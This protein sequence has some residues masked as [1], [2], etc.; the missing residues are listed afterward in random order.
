MAGEIGIEGR[1]CHQCALIGADRRGDVPQ[2]HGLRIVRERRLEQ[3]GITRD[4]SQA[5]DYSLLVG[6]TGCDRRGECLKYL[7][8]EVRT[9][10][11]PMNNKTR[12]GIK[13]GRDVA[14]MGT[15]LDTHRFL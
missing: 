10:A 14:R 3:R 4:A 7:I 13:V 8:L 9:V 6:L 12:P 1:W 15:L 2:R 11:A 5:I